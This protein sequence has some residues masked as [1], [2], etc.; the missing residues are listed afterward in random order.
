MNPFLLTPRERLAD[1][2]QLRTR[3]S[4]L[5]EQEQLQAVALYW[6]Q[7]PLR[8]LAYDPQQPSSWPTPWEMVSLGEWCPQSV[9]IG[10]EFTLRLSGWKSERLGLVLFNDEKKSTPTLALEIDDRLL[11]NYHYA[12]VVDGAGVID[13]VTCRW[14]F[15]GRHYAPYGC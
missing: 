1:W 12:S 7:A 13:F 3:L 6:A 14:R 15:N 10:M 11:L 5:S 4:A 2:K 8:K 9:A